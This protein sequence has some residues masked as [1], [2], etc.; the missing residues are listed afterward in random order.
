[1]KRKKLTA[2]ISAVFMSVLVFVGVIAI[3]SGYGTQDDPLVSLSYINSVFLPDVNKQVDA[4]INQQTQALLGQVDAKIS[5]Y[6]ESMEEQIALVAADSAAVVSDPNVL[7]T[8]ASSVAGRVQN[9]TQSSAGFKLVKLSQGQTMICSV[10]TEV[11]L[12]LGNAT[13]VSS[14]NPGLIDATDATNLPGGSALKKNHMYLCTVDGRGVSAPGG[15]TVL[16]RGAY[17]IK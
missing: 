12:R 10:G 5:S 11:L 17:S 9:Q 16:V 4:R 3:A 13:C 7:A 1:M 8:I 2:A 15:A 14:G 6:R